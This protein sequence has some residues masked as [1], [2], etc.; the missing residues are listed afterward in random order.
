MEMG[1]GESCTIELSRTANTSISPSAK[2]PRGRR[3]RRGKNGREEGERMNHLTL[4]NITDSIIVRCGAKR[5]RNIDSLQE[6]VGRSSVRSVPCVGLVA[7]EKKMQIKIK[8]NV[9]RF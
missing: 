7:K 1:V 4:N 2:K 8:R 3:I 5:P 9:N 6:T